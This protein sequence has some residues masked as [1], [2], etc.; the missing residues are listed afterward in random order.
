MQGYEDDAVQIMTS[1]IPLLSHSTGDSEKNSR[2]GFF[3]PNRNITLLDKGNEF[4]VVL[5]QPYIKIVA[6]Q[7]TIKSKLLP[8]L[9]MYFF[10]KLEV[11]AIPYPVHEIIVF[12][13]TNILVRKAQR[14]ATMHYY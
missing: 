5:Q 11:V 7:N 14:I 10:S 9:T 1:S 6:R 13:Q 3:C 2:I 12:P 8:G 4:G